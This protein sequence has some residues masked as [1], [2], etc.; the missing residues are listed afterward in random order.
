MSA[1]S[2]H[3]RLNSFLQGVSNPTRVI[4][5][6]PD[7]DNNLILIIFVFRTFYITYNFTVY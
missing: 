3:P 4:N 7:I 1:T 5:I 2:A 6:F